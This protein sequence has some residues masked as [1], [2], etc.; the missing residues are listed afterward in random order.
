MG[1]GARCSG[2][3]RR[4]AAGALALALAA[5]L[6]PAAAG[7]LDPSPSPCPRSRDAVVVMTD[8]RELWLCSGGT[9]AAQYA[10]ALG[11]S[12]VGKRRRGDGRTPLGTYPLGDPRPSPQYGTF[13]PIAYPTPAQAARGF[14]GTAVGIHGPPRGTEGAGYPVTEVDWTQGCIAT[15]SDEDVD[16]I[17]AF[18]RARRPRLVIR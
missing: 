4:H 18:V 16:A 15:G 12:G 14:T 1:R 6:A 11:R 13:I 5:A 3:G 17:A 8:R 9:P 7:A 2:D 10:V